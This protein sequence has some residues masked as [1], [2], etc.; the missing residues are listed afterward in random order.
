MQ[1]KNQITWING[2]KGLACMG[3]FLHHFALLFLPATS[4]GEG[5]AV[6]AANGI[7]TF[8]STSILGLPLNGHFHVS[9]FFIVSTF[10]I[11]KSAFTAMQK[12]S[13]EIKK[14][15]DIVLKRYFRL[16]FPVLFWSILFNL[17]IGALIQNQLIAIPLATIPFGEVLSRSFLYVFATEDHTLM[18]QLWCVHYLFLGTFLAVIAALMD[19]KGRKYTGIIY[20]FITLL[21]A[22]VYPHY[23]I[24]MI[25]VDFAYLYTRT[26]F[27]EKLDRMK[28]PLRII[29][30]ILLLCTAIF[31]GAYPTG[32]IPTN[33]YSPFTVLANVLPG[34]TFLLHGIAAFC[35]L[36][37][38][39]FLKPLQKLFSTGLFQFLGDISFGVYLTHLFVCYGLSYKLNEVFVAKT[40]HYLGGLG[41]SLLISTVIILGLS[42]LSKIGP[43]KFTGFILKKMFPEEK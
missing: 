29:L 1:K 35:L 32:V 22:R 5:F 24:L 10:L 16:L 36:L 27:L 2:L 17:V 40:N 42:Y 41:I 21:L 7:D 23:A 6:P 39:L 25:G 33:Y 13:G 3:V 37:A 14:L 30:G 31:F 9:V 43:E 8:L 12:D 28:A 34:Y 15:S 38:F 19:G 11:A 18:P 26:S 4:N 20:V